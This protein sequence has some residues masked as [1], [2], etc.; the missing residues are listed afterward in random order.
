MNTD[1]NTVSALNLMGHNNPPEPTPFELSK[2]A[3]QDLYDEAKLWLD[4]EPVT[5]QH[6]A[7]ALNT[8]KDRIKKATKAAEENRKLDIKPYQE[9]VDAI[10][11]AYNELIGKNKSVTGI[12]I[13]AEEAVNAALRPYLVELDRKQQEAARLA[14]EEADRK[15]EEALAAIRQRDDANL[16]EREQ[17]ELLVKQA[18]E[19]DEAARKAEGAKAHAKGEGRAT[20]LRTVYRAVMT[21]AKEAAAW[22][23]V[24]RRDELMVFIQDQADKAVRAGNRK[25]QGFDIIEEKVL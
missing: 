3:I 13:K 16:A 19:A 9:E 4:G 7:D 5:T 8:L 18:K 6:Q 15:R 2:Q 23:W 12:A 22:V 20:G 14:R 10:Q 21:D 1:M 24:T 17:A 11:A 25:I